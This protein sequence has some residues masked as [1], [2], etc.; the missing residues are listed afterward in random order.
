MINVLNSITPP[1]LQIRA[2]GDPL[3]GQNIVWYSPYVGWKTERPG[4]SE[5]YNL[6]PCPALYPAKSGNG[7]YGKARNISPGING[8]KLGSS[9]DLTG[10]VG[11]KTYF[12]SS[13]IGSMG[14]A[15]GK[16]GS[17]N[18]KS[19]PSYENNTKD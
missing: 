18:Q 2:S 13:K 6:Y 17:S 16:E 10:W 9:T 8:F 14:E 11:E 19:R 1:G 12:N 3:V 5:N 7:N 4:S 15:V